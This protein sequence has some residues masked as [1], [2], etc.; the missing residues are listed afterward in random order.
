M[1][2]HLEDDD[3][4]NADRDHAAGGDQER[5]HRHHLQ[6]ERPAV[7]RRLYGF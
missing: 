7:V 6:G 5:H 2:R 1:H 4:A 3:R